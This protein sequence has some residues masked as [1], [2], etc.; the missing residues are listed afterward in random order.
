MALFIECFMLKTFNFSSAA[1]SP[2]EKREEK[3]K[4]FSVYAGFCNDTPGKNALVPCAGI[5]GDDLCFILS[6]FGFTIQ[7]QVIDHDAQCPRHR[8]SGKH[9]KRKGQISFG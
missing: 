8:R 2:T 7:N 5:F 4:E 1:G 9:Q 6:F 3:T